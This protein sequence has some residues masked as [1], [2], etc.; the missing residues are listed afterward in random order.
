MV[1][2]CEICGKELTELNQ[3]S[4]PC[5]N[6]YFHI[7]SAEGIKSYHVECIGEDKIK[8]L[9]GNVDLHNGEN[10]RVLTEVD[11]QPIA[12]SY[13]HSWEDY[14]RTHPLKTGN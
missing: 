2:K 7:L 13:N 9:M 10:K 12:Y 8:E 5:A 3:R 6:A 1:Y 11:G 4:I 14:K